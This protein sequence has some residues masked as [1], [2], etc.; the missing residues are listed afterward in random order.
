[1]IKN[2][3]ILSTIVGIV[4]SLI[5]GAAAVLAVLLFFNILEVQTL[6]KLPLEL[7]PLCLLVLVL[8]SVFSVINGVSLIREWWR[9]D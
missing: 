7:L 4:Q 3:R 1:M 6:F 9:I 2:R 8:F 5:G